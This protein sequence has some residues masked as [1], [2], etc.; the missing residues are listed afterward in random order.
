MT[1]FVS[2]SAEPLTN[3]YDEVL[4]HVPGCI[5]AVALNAIRQAASEF[6]ERSWVDNDDHAPID[7]VADQAVYPYVPPAEKLVAKPLEVW[8]GTTELVA[9]APGDLRNYFPNWQTATG[10]PKFYTATTK[11]SIR[12]VATPA[13]AVT[14]GL[15]LRVAYM[16]TPN[17]TTVEAVVWEDY[18]EE[19]AA[20]ARRRLFLMAKKPWTN[21]KQAGIEQEFFEAGVAAAKHAVMRGF[22]RA[23]TRARA[24]FF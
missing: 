12:L 18:H 16:P 6:C 8:F 21:I 4:P 2:L 7:I 9:K 11:R 13:E 19:I 1:L 15:T 24:H 22:S 10:V 20:G 3:W 17:A 14:D 5:E 23:K